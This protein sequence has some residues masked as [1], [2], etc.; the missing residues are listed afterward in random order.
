MWKVDKLFVLSAALFDISFRITTWLCLN[1][2][3][4]LVVLPIRV[5]SFSLQQPFC[6]YLYC[7]L[8]FFFISSSSKAS[9]D[10]SWFYCLSKREM[11]QMRT[12]SVHIWLNAGDWLVRSFYK[13]CKFFLRNYVIGVNG[14]IKNRWVPKIFNAKNIHTDFRCERSSVIPLA[15]RK[16]PSTHEKRLA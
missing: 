6:T 1:F 4:I 7:I 5:V 10:I 16:R 13:C 8:F 11:R 3:S 9:D 14:C 2:S 12:Y 15:G